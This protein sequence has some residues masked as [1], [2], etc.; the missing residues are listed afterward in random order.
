VS[1]VSNEGSFWSD[2]DKKTG[3]KTI[4]LLATP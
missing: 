3:F 1:D 4:T 2:A